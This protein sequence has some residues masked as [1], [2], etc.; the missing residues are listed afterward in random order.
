[1]GTGMESRGSYGVF[2]LAHQ[3]G[4]ALMVE[5]RNNKQFKLAACLESAGYNPGFWEDDADGSLY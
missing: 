3:P 5:L 4:G 1:M 2:E